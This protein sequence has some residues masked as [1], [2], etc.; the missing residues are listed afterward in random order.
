MNGDWN[1]VWDVQTGR[2]EGGW[3]VEVAIPFKSLR[4][5]PGR[6]QIWGFNALRTNRWKNEISYLTRVPAARGQ[7]GALPA[8]RLRRRVVGLEAP[9]ARATSSSSRTR[10]PT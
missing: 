9:P 6:A 10:S 3:T 7:S 8:C 1:P 4:Y 2:F 5:R